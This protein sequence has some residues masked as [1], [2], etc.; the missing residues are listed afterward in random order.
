MLVV[1]RA[2]C[3]RV[4]LRHS[5]CAVFGAEAAAAAAAGVAFHAFRV[6]WA[7][8]AAFFDGAV[9]LDVGAPLHEGALPH[10]SAR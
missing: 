1:T 4:S 8:G 6:R 9:P 2:D 5:S 10:A 7:G 3:D